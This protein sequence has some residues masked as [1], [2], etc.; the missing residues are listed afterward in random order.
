MVNICLEDVISGLMYLGFDKV[1]N[2]LLG[3]VLETVL[4]SNMYN[5]KLV[6]YT[7]LSLYRYIDF[8][9]NIYQL[10]S[11]DELK[12][13]EITSLPIKNVLALNSNKKLIDFLKNV[14]FKDI[15]LKKVKCI[16]LNNLCNMN[17]LFSNYEKMIIME[18]FDINLKDVKVKRK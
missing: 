8:D 17:Y 2:L 16:G 3:Y 11:E 4:K 14:D 1:D 18:I 9:N 6:D 15:V 10:K 12:S 5:F 13:N 7:S